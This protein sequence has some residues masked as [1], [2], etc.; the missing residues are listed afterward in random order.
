MIRGVG[1]LA[2]IGD[3]FGVIVFVVVALITIIGQVLTKQREAKA[4]QERL[5]RRQAAAAGAPPQPQPQAQPPKAAELEDEIG[6]FLRRAARGRSGQEPNRP[7]PAG[8]RQP[9]QGMRPPAAVPPRRPMPQ[10][11]P[12]RL[13]PRPVVAE[14]VGESLP[15][16]TGQRVREA[17]TKDLDTSELKRHAAELGS[18]ARAV[19][20]VVEQRLG[21]K[22]SREVGTLGAESRKK[23]V[24]A[25]K[26]KTPLTD[27][28]ATSAA[29]FAALLANADSIRQAIV[30]NEILQRPEHRW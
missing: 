25:R 27:M 5:A 23:P 19:H 3:V 21:E 4:A 15:P 24:A 29:G 10:P 20:E 8:Q 30:L 6:E 26:A 1:L 13:A 14:V 12:S 28:P 7:G 18:G 11:Q 16:A 22:F 9:A 2:A 17:V